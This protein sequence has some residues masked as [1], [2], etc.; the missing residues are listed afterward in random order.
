M[1]WEP[2]KL[3][4]MSPEERA[5]VIAMIQVRAERNKKENSRRVGSY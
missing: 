4:N 5:M 1:G 3:V 2:S